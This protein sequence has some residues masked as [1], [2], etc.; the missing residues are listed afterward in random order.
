MSRVRKY[1]IRTMNSVS[2]DDSIDKVIKN[3]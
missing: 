2:P 1:M 3:M